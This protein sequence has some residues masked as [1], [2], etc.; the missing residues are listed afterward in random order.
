MGLFQHSVLQKYLNDADQT[1]MKAAYQKLAEF[2][3]NPYI[4]RMLI[5]S[6]QKRIENLIFIST[7]YHI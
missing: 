6:Y 7:N 1:E 3:Q 4:S 2:F 5:R